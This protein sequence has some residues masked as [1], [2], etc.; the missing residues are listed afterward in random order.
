MTFPAGEGGWRCWSAAP[1]W[2]RTC[3]PTSDPALTT[4][5]RWGLQA[6]GL[7]HAQRPA[8]HSSVSLAA[9]GAPCCLWDPSVPVWVTPAPHPTSPSSFLPLHSSAFSGHFRQ[10]HSCNIHI[11]CLAPFTEQGRPRLRSR[12]LFVVG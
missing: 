3:S 9:R 6:L 2:T 5:P 7:P 10:M 11:L 4:L 12:F 1:S 8:E